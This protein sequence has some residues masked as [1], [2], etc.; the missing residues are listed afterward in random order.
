MHVFRASE[1][2]RTE[3]PGHFGHLEVADVVTE[4]NGARFRTQ[5]SY[6]PPGGG[7]EMH[8]HDEHDQLFVVIEGELTFDTGTERFTL[9][10]QEAVLFHAGD[11]HYTLNESDKPSVSVVITVAA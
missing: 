10:E 4:A 7:G 2:A 3:P 8:H 6:C 11:P 5:L 9:H 1:A